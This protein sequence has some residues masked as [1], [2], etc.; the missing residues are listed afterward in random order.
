M[1]ERLYKAVNFYLALTT[2]YSCSTRCFA[3][4]W[5]SVWNEGYKFVTSVNLMHL[6]IKQ[7]CHENFK[8]RI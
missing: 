4:H 5:M 6:I 8:S 7:S 2:F 1:C 3:S